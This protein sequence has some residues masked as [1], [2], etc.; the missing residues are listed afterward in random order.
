MSDPE[1]LSLWETV[2]RGNLWWPSL[3]PQRN[4]VLSWRRGSDPLR[5]FDPGPV[6]AALPDLIETLYEQTADEVCNRHPEAAA[7][8]TYVIWLE[9]WLEQFDH[10]NDPV[11]QLVERHCIDPDARVLAGMLTSLDGAA[12]FDFVLEAHERAV[13]ERIALGTLISEPLMP[14]VPLAAPGWSFGRLSHSLYQRFCTEFGYQAE[15]LSCT[16][17]PEFDFN[18]IRQPK[19]IAGEP[20]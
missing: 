12:I 7:G 18:R 1:K 17:N 16:E 19:V 15:D 2:R 4:D 20:A 8:S 11:C 13:I 3:H 10:W 6:F 14:V 5:H 9:V